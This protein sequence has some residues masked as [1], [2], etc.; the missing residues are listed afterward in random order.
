MKRVSVLF[1]ALLL[2]AASIT[3]KELPIVGK[4]LLTIAEVDGHKQEV[5]SEVVFKED[6]YAEMDG[7][8]FGTWDYDKKSKSI[9]IESKMIEEFA[10]KRTV[11]NP[12]KSEMMFSGD[13]LILHFLKLDEAK[14]KKENDASGLLGLWQFSKDQETTYIKFEAP[15]VVRYHSITEYS[16]SS[17]A[18]I[19]MYNNKEQTVIL[20]LN[21]RGLSG[22]NKVEEITD[23]TF[24]IVKG[25]SS[26]DATKVQGAAEVEALSFTAEDIN[27]SLDYR[28]ENLTFD[29]INYL[30]KNTEAKTQYLKN[31]SKLSYSHTEKITKLNT[32]IANEISAS[33]SYDEDYQQITSDPIF[34]EMSSEDLSEENLFYPLEIG[35]SYRIIGDEIITVPAGTFNCKVVEAIAGYGDVKLKVYMISNRPGVYAK[36]I[37]NQE[38][39]E[40]VISQQ[41]ELESI[42]SNYTTSTHDIIGNWLL[43]KT[44]VNGKTRKKSTEMEFVNDGRYIVGESSGSWEY[45]DKLLMDSYGEISEYTITEVSANKL[46]YTNGEATLFFIKW[47]MSGNANSPLTGY[48]ALLQGSDYPYNLIY[49]S[50]EGNYYDIENVNEG[51]VENNSAQKMGQWAH[52]KEGN[53]LILNL[54]DEQAVLMGDYKITKLENDL[55]VLDKGIVYVKID[56]EKMAK[57]NEASGLVGHWKIEMGQHQFYYFNLEAPYLIKGGN[58]PEGMYNQNLWFY[59]PETQNFYAGVEK[60]GFGGLHKVTELTADTITFESG[61]VATRIK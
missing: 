25:E 13:G 19:W 34:G 44:E 38:D 23:N 39:G 47:D 40:E 35:R 18:G 59:N 3:A 45:T 26:I 9:T 42:E 1:F 43:I 30:W 56:P 57:N 46:T 37:M 28:N 7:R 31:V 52:N 53:E 21:N 58:S 36:I 51:P 49:L 60:Y 12:S 41:F 8:V 4:W 48:W 14:I 54:S 29:A 15:N 17:G 27:E 2:S 10:G 61:R 16:S 5:Y 20:M 22:N 24:K 55:M 32:Y 11:S 6:G 50:K 33:I